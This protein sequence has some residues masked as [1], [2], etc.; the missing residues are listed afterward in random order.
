MASFCLVS[1]GCGWWGC[2][3]F[4]GSW[5]WSWNTAEVKMLPLV[6]LNLCVCD[7]QTSD[8][9][10]KTVRCWPKSDVLRAY[11]LREWLCTMCKGG[12]RRKEKKQVSLGTLRVDKDGLNQRER[13][14]T[15]IIVK[16]WS[17]CMVMFCG[18]Y[19]IFKEYTV[20]AIEVILFLFKMNFS[21]NYV[22]FLFSN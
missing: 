12:R 16:K 22:R 2:S 15:K 19:C 3:V 8:F 18:K 1:R 7:Q 10:L 21:W 9:V 11:Y 4:M 20:K 6:W 13:K 14:Q 17:F 5:V